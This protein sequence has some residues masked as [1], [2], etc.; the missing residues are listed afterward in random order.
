M[1]GNMNIISNGTRA[2]S[3]GYAVNVGEPKVEQIR[4]HLSNSEKSEK[5]GRMVSVM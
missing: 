4:E 1:A 5:D 2:N 3:D